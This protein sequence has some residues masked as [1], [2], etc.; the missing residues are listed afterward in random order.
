MTN[1]ELIE[2]VAQAICCESRPCE[3]RCNAECTKRLFN[4]A[5]RAAIDVVVEECARVAESSFAFDIETWLN[6]TKK[7][8]TAHT[9]NAIAAAIRSLKP[10][11]RNE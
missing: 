4:K 7:E 10:G 3:A 9:G 5:A 6:S 2:T 1:D 8:M 11:A